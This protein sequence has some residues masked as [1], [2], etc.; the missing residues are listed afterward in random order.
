MTLLFD[1]PM[2]GASYEVDRDLAGM[3]IRCRKCGDLNRVLPPKN[4]REKPRATTAPTPEKTN[5]G[6]VTTRRNQHMAVESAPAPLTE[7]EQDEP[8]ASA[9]S[10]RGILRSRLFWVA[11]AL[12]LVA[13]LPWLLVVAFNRDFSPTSAATESANRRMND[14]ALRLAQAARADA[15]ALRVELERQRNEL[16]RL[17]G[18][19]QR[20][21]ANRLTEDVLLKVQ[22]KV[23]DMEAIDNDTRTRLVRGD[24]ETLLMFAA[25]R[26]DP[27][28]KKAKPVIA[29]YT[30]RDKLISQ[31]RSRLSQLLDAVSLAVQEVQADQNVPEDMRTS[32]ALR[33]APELARADALAKRAYQGPDLDI[34]RTE[35]SKIRKEAAEKSKRG[36]DAL[37]NFMASLPESSDRFL[38]WMDMHEVFFMMCRLQL[39]HRENKMTREEIQKELHGLL[40]TVVPKYDEAIEKLIKYGGACRITHDADN[41]SLAE[42][43]FFMQLVLKG[44]V[45]EG[46]EST[47]MRKR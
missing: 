8:A 28:N 24:R 39:L 4:Q 30:A 20:E 10:V 22:S 13:G 36:A 15:D 11:A 25:A 41:P 37:D 32:F 26:M 12:P 5:P 38:S 21:A 16:A 31:S 2:C 44:E 29:Y 34:Y 9:R 27:E 47:G 18:E 23:K 43:Y 33:A 7:Q 17:K 35:L 14:D 42:T 6:A 1:C 3:V 46:G 19:Q 40:P 45:V